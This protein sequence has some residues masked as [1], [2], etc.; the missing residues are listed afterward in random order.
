MQKGNTMVAKSVEP[1]FRPMGF[2]LH[3]GGGQVS[4]VNAPWFVWVVCLIYF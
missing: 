3:E 2:D 1:K 4:T